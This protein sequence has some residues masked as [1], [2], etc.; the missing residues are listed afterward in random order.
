MQ[1]DVNNYSIEAICYDEAAN[2]Y[3]IVVN[4]SDGVAMH[5]DG[6]AIC[7]Y[8]AVNNY[9]IGANYCDVFLICYTIVVVIYDI[10]AIQGDGLVN[11]DDTVLNQD[12]GVVNHYSKIAVFWEMKLTGFNFTRVFDF[13]KVEC[14]I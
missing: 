14:N 8:K 13:G 3:T 12:D 10:V 1:F 11:R 9:A 2:N 5:S 7:Y 6:V 4:N